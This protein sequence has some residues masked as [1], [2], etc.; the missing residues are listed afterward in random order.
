MFGT[1]AN[2]RMDTTNRRR[3]MDIRNH[4]NVLAVLYF[5][6]GCFCAFSCMFTSTELHVQAFGVFLLFKIIWLITEQL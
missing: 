3:V 2:A 1:Y 6:A 4:Q 5:L